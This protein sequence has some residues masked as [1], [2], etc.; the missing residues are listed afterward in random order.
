MRNAAN[1]G[2]YVSRNHGLAEARGVFVTCHDSDD[3]AHPQRLERQVAAL[4]DQP[5][6]MGNMSRCVTATPDLRF[7]NRSGGVNGFR[8]NFSSVL[9][10]RE[11]ALEGV[12]FWDEARFGADGEYV[13]RLRRRFG[14]ETIAKLDRAAGHRAPVGHQPDRARDPGSGRAGPVGAHGLSNAIRGLAP[15]RRP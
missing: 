2:P 7:A 13:A 10:R 1:G 8:W 4:L 15:A 14:R 11:Q 3:W 9:F 12:G 5:E 6:A